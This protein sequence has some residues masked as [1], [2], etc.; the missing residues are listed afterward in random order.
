M[1]A[2]GGEPA[3]ATDSAGPIRGVRGQ[4]QQA[5]RE[6][7]GEGRLADRRRANDQ[8]G[9]RGG[10]LNQGRDGSERA[11]LGP[12]DPLPHRAGHDGSGY[13]A[14]FRVERRFG[15]G[16]AASAK[17]SAFAG[18]ADNAACVD[19]RRRTAGATAAAASSFG[20]AT[21][22]VRVDVRRRGA[23]ASVAPPATVPAAAEPAFATRAAGS[24][25]RRLVVR[26]FWAGA[27]AAAESA[28]TGGSA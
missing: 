25:V 27:T 4:A 5:R 7:V 26:R 22:A 17:A 9:V 3:T 13:S 14:T 28:T 16:F 8:D 2:G 6:I 18:L 11:G 15:A 21:T 24:A 23:G 19:V 10:T 1:V 12:G 20:A